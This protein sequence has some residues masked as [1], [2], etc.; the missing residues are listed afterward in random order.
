M[1]SL[2][3]P[4]SFSEI[5]N[6]S[7]VGEI[8]EMHQGLIPDVSL[9]THFFNDLVE[10]DMLYFALYPGKDGYA[11][12]KDTIS[13]LPNS[14]DDYVDDAENLHDALKVIDARSCGNYRVIKMYMNSMEQRGFCYVD[15]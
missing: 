7:I 3:I 9:G 5:N 11:I 4:V 10:F 8:A 14:L 6:V 12:R 15:K 13:M 1:P 2:G